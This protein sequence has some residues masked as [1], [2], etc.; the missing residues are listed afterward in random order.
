MNF[1]D[2]L[3]G[4]LSWQKFPKGLENTRKATVKHQ[5]NVFVKNSNSVLNWYAA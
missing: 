2:I 5:G 3:A 1:S 4:K